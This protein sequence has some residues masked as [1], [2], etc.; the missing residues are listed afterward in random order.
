MS[1]VALVRCETYDEKN[2]KK[3]VEKGIRL[4]GGVEKFAKKDEK[5]L[6]KPNLLVADPPEKCVTTHPSVFKAVVEIFLTT[7]ATLTYGDSPA[8]GSAKGA[9]KKAGLKAIGDELNI[10]IA[11]FKTGVDVFYKDGRQNKK[12]VIAKGV[13]EADGII[14]IPKF[15]TH[16][17]E[18]IT[19]CVK[20]QFGCIPGV[21]KGEFHCKVPDADN[22][23]KMLLDL[24]RF[25]NPRLYIVDG[26]TGMDG[27][28]P[29]GGNPR[30]MNLIAL[31]EDPVALD[32]TLCRLIDLNPDFVPT[33]K[34]GREFGMGAFY[35]EDIELLGDDFN[36][37]VCR[38]FDVIRSP[39]RPYQQTGRR[40]FINNRIV[41]K[42]YIVEEKCQM[43]GICVTMCPASP[44]AVDW[45]GRDKTIPPAYNYK[46][47]IR[48]YCCQELCP[49]N[50]IKLKEPLLRKIF[51]VL[52]L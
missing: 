28:G 37:F 22:F 33:V 46:S 35:E 29:R 34:F 18:R 16:G 7:G 20:N 49:E 2:V 14:S 40:K 5:I 39:V 3:A 27:N 4:L 38:D 25:A 30:Q 9:A 11:D 32:A 6:L 24:N 17:L 31:S 52:P 12:F 43:C 48:C 45:Q 47:C 26:I 50:A 13:V 51:N 23:A 1:K 42:P 44:K 15:K 19:C 8:V 41:P 21:L 10:P 36:G